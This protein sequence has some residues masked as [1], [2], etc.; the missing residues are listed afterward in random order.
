MLSQDASQIKFLWTLAMLQV[1]IVSM[2]FLLG[3]Y[4]DGS[5]PKLAYTKA[6]KKEIKHS[7]DAYPL[8]IDVFMMLLGGF[9]YLMTFLKRYGL[10][11]LGITMIITA[12]LTELGIIVM[13]LTRIDNEFVIKIGFVDIMEGGVVAAAVLITFGVLLGKVNPLQMLIIGILETICV[14]LN[15]YLGYT[16]MGANDIGGSIFVHTFGAYF[17]LAIS[18]CLRKQRTE[19]S[20]EREGPRYTSDI[21]SLLGTIILWVFWPSFNG[22]LAEGDARHRCY[23]NTYMSLLGSTVTTF[24][25]SGLLGN[26]KFDLEDIQNATLAGGVMVGATA[27]MVLQPY[28]ACVAGSIAGIVSTVGYKVI[29]GKLHSWLKVH[30]TCGVNN[31]HGMPGLM[32]GILSVL[33]V[34]LASE[35]SYGASLYKIFPLCA[36]TEGSHLFKKIQTDI[37]DIEPG[38]GRTLA[39]QSLVQLLALVITLVAAI[40]TGLVTGLLVSFSKLFEPLAHDQLFDDQPFWNM[41]ENDDV[42]WPAVG[43]EAMQ[44]RKSRSRSI[45]K[46]GEISA[47]S[48]HDVAKDS[49]QHLNPAYIS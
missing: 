14:V 40:I 49:L 16:V 30:D 27:D 9:G 8:G 47:I 39:F 45:S 18:F 3:R 36:P 44:R 17:G 7:L 21:T 11:A 32:A 25:C 31:L 1:I 28:G 13:G 38:E 2:L 20:E 24:M 10:G 15:M 34:I 33:V 12:I 5:N 4:D 41:A 19:M 42:G 35:E 48:R 6:G 22:L 37:P 29:S 46:Q 43:L 26:R 23:I